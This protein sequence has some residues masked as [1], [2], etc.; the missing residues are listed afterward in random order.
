MLFKIFHQNYFFMKYSILKN[1]KWQKNKAGK[2]HKPSFFTLE[3]FIIFKIFHAKHSSLK[4][5]MLWIIKLSIPKNMM[6]SKLSLWN[7]P[8]SPNSN[9][10][11][12]IKQHRVVPR[13]QICHFR[14]MSWSVLGPFVLYQPSKGCHTNT[15]HLTYL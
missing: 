13:M 1:Q 5:F 8:V 4:S 2:F 10:A 11:V 3:N 12:T 6:H 15:S 14:H 7:F 9:R